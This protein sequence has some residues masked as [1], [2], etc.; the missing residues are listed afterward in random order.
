[1]DSIQFLL[2]S[3]GASVTNIYREANQ[4][5]NAFAKFGLSIQTCSKKFHS[6]RFFAVDAV[7]ADFSGTSFPNGNNIQA[8]TFRLIL[9]RL[10]FNSL[11]HNS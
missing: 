4:V 3:L 5:A 7:R 10:K 8:F 1:M 2:M 6:V 9:Y 11:I